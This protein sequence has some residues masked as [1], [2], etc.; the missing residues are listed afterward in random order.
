MSH[1]WSTGFLVGREAWHGLADV[2]DNPP[3]SVAELREWM[4]GTDPITVPLPPI[5]LDSGAIVDMSE[6]SAVVDPNTGHVHQPAVTTNNYRIISEQTCIE[7]GLALQDLSVAEFD[8]ISAATGTPPVHIT[9]AMYLRDGAV[10][11]I[12]A[13]VSNDLVL[14]DGTSHAGLYLVVRNSHDGTMAFGA[15][16]T[17]VLTECMNTLTAGMRRARSSFTIRHTKNAG[18]RIAE[19][20]KALGIASKYRESFADTAA[21]LVNTPMPRATFED[22]VRDIYPRKDDKSLAPFSEEQYALLGVLDRSTTINDSW[23]DTLWGGLNAVT[24]YE[25][26]LRNLRNTSK[27]EAERRLESDLWGRGAKNGQAAFDYLTRDLA[28]MGAGA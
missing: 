21:Q 8:T 3:S 15:Q 25:T 22:M 27:S 16:I 24:E 7:F 14:A 12:C 11:A 1:E 10:L 28:G 20:K 18:D 17:T 23:R 5:I 2:R 9:S 6:W 13:K 26:W 19:A 4:G